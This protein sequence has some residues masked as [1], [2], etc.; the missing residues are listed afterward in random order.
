M[1][2]LLRNNRLPQLVHRPHT[3][4]QGATR[5]L[6]APYAGINLRDDLTSLKPN[7][8]RVLENWVSVSGN[9]GLRDGYDEHATGV[10]TGDVHTIAAFIGLTTSKMI[11]SA[12]G[13]IYDVTTA[14]TATRLATGF[15]VNRFQT[16]LYNNRLLMVNG[17]EAPHDFD[18]AGMAATAWSGTGLTISNLV[19]VANVRNR[20]W[21]CE[22]NSA[23][24]WY[25][26]I[27]SITGALTKFQLSQ[28][29][30]GGVCMAIGSWSRDAGAGADD[31]TVFIMS[32]GEIIVYQGD[33]ATTF[34]LV[35]K[36]A[37]APPIGRQCTFKVGGDLIVITRLGI[38]P[39]SA[40]IG[41]SVV[42][43]G[44]AL[45]L[46][47]INPWGKIAPGIVRDAVLHG[48]ES[49]WSG[50]LHNGIVYVN[51]PQV[52]GALTKQRVL[53]TRTGSWSDFTG[54]PASSL[55]SF[56]HKIYMGGWDGRVLLVG[57][58]DD[59]G[60]AITA[61]SSGAFV[62]PTKRSDLNNLFTAIR[63]K[64][65]TSG[66]VSGLVG[67]DTDYVLRSR[68]GEPVIVSS[69]VNNTPWGSP[70][71]SPWGAQTRAEPRWFSITGEGRSVSVRFQATAQSSDVQW[72]AT[73]I[74]FKPGGIR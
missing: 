9:L 17:S 18:G 71:G 13:A 68:I 23:D 12:N 2:L 24:V 66:G 52:A 15:S 55:C 16:A 64:V 62:V 29:A 4:E 38:L 6:P 8:A 60:A 31:A 7:E 49:G 30:A 47:K 5:T 40:A 22:N 27:G 11:A 58:N 72:F 10:G 63:P 46:T 20:I 70:W 19:N 53:N 37:G 57:A 59:E 74:E 56:N 51:I 45:D 54:W 14:G 33:P 48:S 67:V 34:S 26:G 42:G 35:G 73:D 69:D 43:D 21:F 32:T 25:S 1:A 36:F 65:Q 3:F 41:A 28:I 50:L 61:R 44:I 39:V